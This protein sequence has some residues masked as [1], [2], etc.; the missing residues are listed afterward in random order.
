MEWR[1]L[2]A[3]SAKIQVISTDPGFHA[4]HWEALKDPKES[5]PLC[6]L[7]IDLIHISGKPAL[8]YQV[9][10][11]DCLNLLMVTAR[12]FGKRDIEYRTI[13]R[14]VVEMI[15]TKRLRVRVHL[16]RPPTFQHLQEHLREKKGFYHIVH[17]D[18]HGGVMSFAGYLFHSAKKRSGGQKGLKPYKGTK[19]FLCM[20]DEEGWP[21]LVT[22]AEAAE[23]LQEAHVP[24]CFLD[25]CRSAMMTREVKEAKNEQEHART[26]GASLAMILMEKGVNLVLGNAWSVTVTGAKAMM[27]EVYN[28]LLEEEDI[29]KAVNS[30]RLKMAE[31]RT[32]MV[33]GDFTLDLEDWLLP[34]IWGKGDFK[35]QLKKP[36]MEDRIVENKPRE[37]W[38]AETEGMKTTGTYGFIGRDVDILQ[39]ESH[40]QSD[41]ILLI[42]GMGGTGKT[43]LLGHM[44]LWWWKTGWIDHAFYFGYDQKPYR[45]E[46]ILNRVAEVVMPR[47]EFGNFLVMPSLEMKTDELAGYLKESKTTPAVLLVLDNLES[48][49]GAE[50]AV[51]SRLAPADQ[52]DLVMMLR[53]LLKSSIKI[54]LGSRA[55]EAWL[56][57]DTFKGNIYRLEGLDKSSRFAL[58]REILKKNQIEA[59]DWQEFGRLLE[60]LAGYPLV[61]EIILPNLALRTAKE[62]REMLT[63]EGV[64]IQ[65]RRISEEIFK[66]IDISFSLLTDQARCGLMAF[67]PFTFFLNTVEL[68]KYLEALQEEGLFKETTMADLEEALAQAEKQGLVK[69]EEFEKCYALQPVFPFFL[70][71]QVMIKGEGVGREGAG[72]L[73]KAFCR[74][75]STL[76]QSYFQLMQ[77]KESGQRQMGQYLF[78]QDRENLHKALNRVLTAQEDFYYLYN[79]FGY[80]YFESPGYREA[81]AWMEE[82][83]GK[84]EGYAEAKRDVEFLV[85]YASVLGN[86][87]A[88]YF[89]IN[90]YL[91]AKKKNQQAQ[92]LYEKAGRRHEMAAGYHQLGMIAE[93]ERDFAEAKRCYLEALNLKQEFNDHY[94]QA[95]TYHNLGIVAEDERDFTEALRDCSLALEIFIQ[96]HDEYNAGIAISN[97]GRLFTAWESPGGAI[98]SLEISD[99][100]KKI[101]SEILEKT[102]KKSNED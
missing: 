1:N 60:I 100:I 78:R 37:L 12:P 22:A 44:A 26:T 43:T 40:L 101:I 87:G 11:S 35:I 69:E 53:R 67:A 71:Q 95:S 52:Q 42:R 5:K 29:L 24:I 96:Y 51:G 65:G 15:E 102:R 31:D 57:K 86:L 90:D 46:E 66:C 17:L 94:G 62:M 4:L 30:G 54:L 7:G 64:D 89:N 63:G 81:I 72:A 25:V 39:V 32:R 77:S 47:E 16:L 55:D 19:T 79:V 3:S 38:K 41:K 70:W 8:P 27:T 13:T 23:L 68:E 98:A 58:A 88:Q 50:R 34:V 92:E 45:A 48:V 84:L 73:E 82:V 85:N 2:A 33:S 20:V 76:A 83:A 97:L 21:D 61:M 93:A 56:G 9:K 59:G 14:P 91:H 74:Y 80:Y 28:Q 99:P 18:M 36:G 75:M 10:D 49:T 6:L